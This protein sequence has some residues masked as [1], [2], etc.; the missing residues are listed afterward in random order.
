MLASALRPFHSLNAGD[1]RF[2]AH[3]LGESLVHG[4]ACL[5]N[6]MC[7]GDGAMNGYMDLGKTGDGD[8]EVGLSA[9][10]WSIEYNLSNATSAP[11]SASAPCEPAGS[12]T[13]L[14]SCLRRL[15]TQS[16]RRDTV[17]NC[18]ILGDNVR[19]KKIMKKCPPTAK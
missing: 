7:R 5:P 8:C 16:A 18:R 4:D 9:A 6:I 15:W 14:D 10:V 1:C 17:L 13:Q 12:Q 19:S 2:K 3:M 11:F